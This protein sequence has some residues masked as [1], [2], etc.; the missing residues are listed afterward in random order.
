VRCLEV[1]KYKISTI[2]KSKII[3]CLMRK[4]KVDLVSINGLLKKEEI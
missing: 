4:D 3:M 2:S 1:G